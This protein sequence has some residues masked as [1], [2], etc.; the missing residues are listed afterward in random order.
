M[1]M[2]NKTKMVALSMLLLVLAFNTAAADSA[3][4][5]SGMFSPGNILSSTTPASLLSIALLIM[6]V[7]LLIAGIVYA[8]GYALRIDKLIRFAKSEIGEVIITVILV[9]VFV[10]SFTLI[11]ASA[12]S[13]MLVI[14]KGAFGNNLYMSDCEAL[15]GT[16]LSFIGPIIRLMINEIEI[17]AYSSLSIEI[18]PVYFGIS[19]SPLNG[20]AVANSVIKVMINIAAAFMGLIIATLFL[21]LIVYKLFPLFFFAGIVLRTIP[22]T[23]AAG[24]AFIGL[25]VAFYI[26]LPTMVY[27]FTTQ[28]T[29]QATSSTSS[30]SYGSLLSS[31]ISSG[32]GSSNVSGMS[33]GSL[34][35][36]GLM[37]TGI[38]PNFI[39]EVLE[40]TLF[41]VIGIVL[42]FIIAY[43]FMET[44]GD[45]LGAPSL[46]SKNTLKK[47]L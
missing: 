33:S 11:S 15:Y 14:S 23:R 29:P 31:I 18:M 35:L 37:G 4:F 9:F 42:S 28:Y 46:S 20:L 21:L 45:L 22:W 43:N 24:G 26:I 34:S 47:L 38:L 6:L 25:F 3:S 39:R 40:P 13:G 16:S 30:T 1:A 8:L 7:M 12:P 44:L 17:S 2:A 19:V 41:Y 10:G 5:C 36:M 27:I 32:R